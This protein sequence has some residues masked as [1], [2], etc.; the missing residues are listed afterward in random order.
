MGDEVINPSV[1]AQFPSCP[2]EGSRT[3]L[4]TLWPA[5]MRASYG[6]GLAYR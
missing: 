4:S 3:G 6:S 1:Q 5:K 2:Y